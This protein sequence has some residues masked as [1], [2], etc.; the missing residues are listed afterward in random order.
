MNIILASSSPRRTEILNLVKIPHLVIPSTIEEQI[1]NT[2]TPEQVVMELSYQKA[3]DVAEKYPNDLVIG[4]DTIV[5]I[6]NEILGKPKN[7]QDAFTMLSKLSNRTHHVITGVTIVKNKQIDKFYVTSLV[8]FNEMSNKE[9][10]EYINSEYIYDKAGSYAIQGSCAKFIKK[11]EGDYY[12][13][14]G[15]PVSIIYEKIRK[16][17]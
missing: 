6:D 5:V 3:S 13:I 2:L 9:I 10:E 7:Y 1:D 4:A 14:M 15:L 17:M 16:D 12:N 8:T 11:I